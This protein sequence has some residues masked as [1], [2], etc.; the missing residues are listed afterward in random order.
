MPFAQGSRT[1]LSYVTETTFGTTPV[2]NFI[3]LPYSTHTLDL[4]KDRVQGNDIEPDRMQRHDRH[5]NRNALGDIVFDLRADNYD[6]LLESLMFSTWDASPSSAPDELKVG[7]TL[8]SFSIEDYAADVDQAR[9]FTGMVVS[10][11]QFSIRPNQM[12]TTTMSFIGQNM[13]I[14]ATQKTVTAAAINSPF[15]AYSGALEVGDNGSSLSSIA[16]VTGIDFSVNNGVNPTF[17]VGSSTTPQLE[18]GMATVEGTITAYFEDLTLINRFLNE[19]ESALSVTVNDPTAA[20]QYGFFFPKVKFNGASLPVANPQ[21]RI[22]TIPFV[23]LYDATEGSNLV[24]TRPDT[25]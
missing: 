18:Y 21:S 2:G 6:A 24:I 16:T 15:D 20:N 12:V 1:G 17:V 9:L 23:S 19:V 4:T 5:G 14:S 22:I 3:G 11:A 13:A 25:A 8:K 7:T 10:Q